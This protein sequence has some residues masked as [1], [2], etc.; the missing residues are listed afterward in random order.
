MVR[1][2]A[3]QACDPTDAVSDVRTPD[4]LDGAAGALGGVERR[5]VACAAPRGRCAAAAEPPAETG[6]GRPSRTGEPAGHAGHAAALAPAAGP[7][8]ADLSSQGRTAAGRCQA[9]GADRADGAR[10]PRAGL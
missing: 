8:A 1:L 2:A 4:R 3:S 5:R 6:L 7:L 9:G 10:E